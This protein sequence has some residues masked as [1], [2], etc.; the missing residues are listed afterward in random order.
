MN[1][2]A[3]VTG[4]YAF[5]KDTP[6]PFAIMS[7]AQLPE[8]YPRVFPHNITFA[9]YITAHMSDLQRLARWN[10]E[11]KKREWAW[12][13]FPPTV[14]SLREGFYRIQ[15]KSIYGNWHHI[16]IAARRLVAVKALLASAPGLPCFTPKCLGGP[17]KGLAIRAFALEQ[18]PSGGWL[19]WTLED[20]RFGLVLY[21][22][23]MVCLAIWM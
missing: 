23:V 19:K 2:S 3:E 4:S 16:D 9:E 22:I 15:W 21:A 7:L 14:H 5:R 13:P 20:K 8:N 17:R 12:P 6:R 11:H 1:R 10:D 18:V